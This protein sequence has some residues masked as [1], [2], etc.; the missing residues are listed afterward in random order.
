M[1]MISTP[2]G[3]VKGRYTAIKVKVLGGK[4]THWLLLQPIK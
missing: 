4:N 2:L 3:M 1:L